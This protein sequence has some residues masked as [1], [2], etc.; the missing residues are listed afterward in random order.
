MEKVYL[1]NTKMST[2]T[3][4]TKTLHSMTS[5]VIGGHMHLDWEALFHFI[6]HS[7]FTFHTLSP[8]I[9]YTHTRDNSFGRGKKITVIHLASVS[10][11]FNFQI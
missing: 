5:V 6:L 4:D 7:C 10:N 11:L 9:L 3:N 2:S 1:K 8:T